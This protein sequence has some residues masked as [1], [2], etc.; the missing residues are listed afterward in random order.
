[1][2]GLQGLPS[3]PGLVDGDFGFGGGGLGS[4]PVIDGGA[5][6]SDHGVVQ[7]SVGI[8]LPG[9]PSVSEG[10]PSVSEVNGCS[11]PL[12]ASTLPEVPNLQNAEMPQSRLRIRIRKTNSKATSGVRVKH[13][14]RTTAAD[15][16]PRIAEIY[17]SDLIEPPD[18]WCDMKA[19]QD[20][21]SSMS[22]SLLVESV[23]YWKYLQ[24]VHT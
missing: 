3:L 17:G 21:L 1:M 10:L 5:F 11:L 6:A 19:C 13:C 24:V 4:L 9:L 22:I 23:F 14:L 2:Q 7:E 16:L 8:G 18:A 15:D 12:A 20:L